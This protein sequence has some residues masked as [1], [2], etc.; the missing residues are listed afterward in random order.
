LFVDGKSANVLIKEWLA[1]L[2]THQLTTVCKQVWLDVR[3]M[4]ICKVFGLWFQ[5]DIINLAFVV[6]MNFYL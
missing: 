5:L 3:P 4:D 1:M 2:E 6:T